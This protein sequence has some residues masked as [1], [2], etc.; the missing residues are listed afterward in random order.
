MFIHLPDLGKE[1]KRFGNKAKIVK[2]K[3]SA[4]PKPSIPIV[5][6]IA[7]PWEDIDPTNKEPKIGPVQE[8][9][10]KT[11]VN[12]IKNIPIKPPIELDLESIELIQLEGTVIS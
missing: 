12:A 9:E 1:D 3:A 11:R 4:N 7:P 5:N 6:C 10:T 8:K 2:G